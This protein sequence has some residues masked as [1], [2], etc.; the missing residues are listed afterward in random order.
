MYTLDLNNSEL[1]SWEKV[2][3]ACKPPPRSRHTCT[4]VKHFLVFFGGLN[5]RTRYADVWVY[6]TKKKEWTE[7]QCEGGEE[8]VPSPRAH[9]SATLVGEQL[10]IFGGYGGHG[11]SSNELFV[12]D[13]GTALD[14]KAEEHVAPKWTKPV[15]KGKGPTPRFDHQSTWFPDKFVVIGGKDNMVMH[16]DTHHLDL[17]TMT[18][19]EDGVG[20]PPAYTREISNHQLSAIE[21]VPNFKM[22][23]LTGKKG[24]NDFLNHVEV[25][26]CGNMVWNNP[27][28]IGT[29]PRW[30]T[31]RRRAKSYSSEAGATVG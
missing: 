24:A 31:T 14:E 9:H 16:G 26:D 25:M 30:H 11:K 5:H 1:L 27:P 21:S 3:D 15:L 29:P 10:F 20:V 13:F 18:W 23:C 19:I 8:D 7:L 28:A 17:Q 22:F 4:V 2:S 12:L 6:D